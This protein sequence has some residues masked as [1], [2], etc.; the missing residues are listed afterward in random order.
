MLKDRVATKKKNAP[1]WVDQQVMISR[2]R[3]MLPQ[4]STNKPENQAHEEPP[5]P[6]KRARE[7]GKGMVCSTRRMIYRGD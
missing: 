5:P 4:E 7:S 1:G 6:K 3:A 2:G